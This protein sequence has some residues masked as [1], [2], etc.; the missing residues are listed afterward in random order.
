MKVPYLKKKRR[1][2]M[3]A[4][5]AEFGAAIA[6]NL[7]PLTL[8]G[9]LKTGWQANFYPVL[10][11]LQILLNSRHT[12]LNPSREYALEGAKQKQDG[13]L[14]LE[15]LNAFQSAPNVAE[16]MQFAYTRT[17]FSGFIEELRSDLLMVY[18]HSLT[19]SYRSAAI[20][21]RCA[22]EDLYR[23]LFY[24]DH[25]QEFM[26]LNE[27]RATEYNMDLSPIRFREYARRTSYLRCYSEVDVFFAPKPADST[28]AMDLFGLNEELY[29]SL[30]A[31]VHGASKDWFAAIQNAAS[32]KENPEKELKLAS[33]CSQFS[34]LVVAFLIAAHRDIFSSAGDYDKS[35]VLELYTLEERKNFR[36]LLNL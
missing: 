9:K 1:E 23:H 30:S 11:L 31:A 6:T 14:F 26:A 10:A 17:I 36:R 4:L 35:I 27:K 5:A 28:T 24:M 21:L 16:A 33:L 19:Y 2:E 20:G 3:G 7:A 15:A 12:I 13:E 25:P 18:L 8:E 29:G 34:K 22:L 32:L